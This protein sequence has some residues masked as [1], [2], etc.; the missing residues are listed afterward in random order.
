MMNTNDKLQLLA[1]LVAIQS[2]DANETSVAAYLQDFLGQHGITSELVGDT[3][4]RMNL[5]ATI[6]HGQGPILAFSGH[7]D[8]VHEGDLATWSSDPFSLVER[9]GR[10]YGRGT[11]DMKAGLAA[12]AIAMVELKA[13]EAEL[14]GTLRFLL[15]MD[16]E[17]T[18]TGARY[19]TDHGYLDGVEAMVIGEPTGVPVTEIAA[20]FAS[21]GAVIQPDALEELEARLPASTAPEQH[22]IFFAHKGFLVYDV[23]A[24]GKAAHSSMPNIGVNALDHLV[25]Y[26]QREKALYASFPEVSEVM[27][28]TMHNVGVFNGGQQ[29]NSIP[30]F[31]SLTVMTRV[32]PEL[33]PEVIIARLQELIDTMNAEDPTQQL[34]LVVK[35]Y[36][37]AVVT[38]PDNRLV[39]LAQK[40]A[41]RYLKEAMDLPLITVGMGTDASQFVKANPN[42]SL[43]VVGPGNNTAHMPD[44]YVERETYLT[45]PDFYRDLALDYLSGDDRH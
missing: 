7:A 32:I 30:D 31:A 9:D 15:T 43:A 10:L 28:R 41:H 25:D 6:G 37:A 44:E 35:A 29:Q 34:Q 14:N 40:H 8:T 24:T 4:D 12:F 36:D 13:R 19:L 23:T 26:Y 39:D 27:G 16:E 1:D 33:P 45:M 3:P 20:Y 18:Q 17:K 21:G 11:T 22:F 42:M 38:N 5:V 2:V